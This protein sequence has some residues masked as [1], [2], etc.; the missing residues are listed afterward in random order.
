MLLNSY[1]R[2]SKV[3]RLAILAIVSGFLRSLRRCPPASPPQL[4]P[5]TV[6]ELAQ[7]MARARGQLV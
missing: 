5:S 3:V 2:S 7:G 6:Q 1:L 4:L